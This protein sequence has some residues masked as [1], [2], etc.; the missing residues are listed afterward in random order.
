MKNKIFAL[1]L[2]FCFLFNLTSFAADTEELNGFYDIGTYQNVD[3]KPYSGDTEVN[4]TMKN[5]DGDEELEQ[6]YENSD[7]IE[8]SYTAATN[9]GYYG[10]LLVEGNELPTKDNK[11]IYINQLTAESNTV[12]FNVYPML[13]KK[14]TPLSLYISSNVEGFELIKVPLNYYLPMPPYVLGDVNGDNDWNVLDALMTL[15]IGAGLRT[16]S[17]QELLSADVNK[18]S[19]CNVL[20]ALMI[21]QYGA[22]LRTSLE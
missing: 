2:V 3:I 16:A 14:A 19:D 9:G 12:D 15:Q 1:L 10:V 5:L 4:A 20:D 11:I 13:P 6:L 22:G 21:L 17:E 18:D 7:R 8:V